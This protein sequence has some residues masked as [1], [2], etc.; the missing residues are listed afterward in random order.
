MKFDHIA[1]S[2]TCHPERRQVVILMCLLL[3]S[4]ISFLFVSRFLF[5]GAMVDGDS[6]LPGLG[7]G[8]RMLIDRTAYWRGVPFAGD[9]VAIQL[10]GE[11]LMVKRVIGCPNDVVRIPDGRVTVN[12]HPLPESYLAA[13]T[14]TQPGRLSTNPYAVQPECYFVLGDNRGVSVDSRFFGAVPRDR[15]VGRV[16][17]LR[18]AWLNLSATI[19]GI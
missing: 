18:Q 9:I 11:D 7:N 2:A 3:W 15:I 5:R 12:G 14:V 13:G 16:T 4:I 17:G 19:T 10:P 1:R 8:D 6:M